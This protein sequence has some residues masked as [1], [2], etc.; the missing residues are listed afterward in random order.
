MAKAQWVSTVA[1]IVDTPGSTNGTALSARFFIPHGI[2]A[3]TFGRIFIADRNN[4]IIR[5][6][7]TNT[8]MV[9]T[10]AGM[11]GEPG[12]ANGIG[13]AARF[14]EPWGICATPDGEVY[15]AD[16][17]NNMVRKVTLDGTVTTI[18]GTGNYGS[19][20]GVGIASTFG[21]PTG[22]ERDADGNL[23]V[24]DHLTHIIRKINK[25]G[26]VS[27]LAGSPYVPGDADGTGANA[28]FWRPYGLTLDH[29]GNLLVADEWNHKIRKV[30]PQGEVTTLAGN[31]IDGLTDGAAGNASFSYPWD[32]TVDADGNV[33]VGD[34][35]NYVVRK[36]STDGVVTTFSGTPQSPGIQDGSG[37]IAKFKGITS[38]A[39]SKQSGNLV[40]CDAFNHLIRE[41]SVEGIPPVTLSL[42]NLEG[43]SKIC[44]GDDFNL[45]AAPSTFDNY[46]FYLDGT[47]VQDN[48]SSDFTSSQ[49]TPGMHT[50]VA[51]TKVDGQTLTSNPVV[52]TVVETPQP[53]ISAVGP[54]SFYEGDSVILFASGIG[55]FLW[56]NAETDQTITVSESGSYFVELSLNGCTG[57]SPPIEVTVTDLPDA[58]SV[59]VQGNNRLCPG[60]SVVLA[61]SA[62]SGNQWFR[63]GWPISG[64]NGQTIE[65]TEAGLY[66]VQSTDPNTGIT[67]LSNEVEIKQPQAF[68]F[69]FG[70]TPS[71]A[72]PG[73]PIAFE[74]LGTDQPI[75]FEWQFG[76]PN[77]GLQNT[78]QEPKPTHVFALEGSYTIQLVATDLNGC[79]HTL[80]KTDFVEIEKFNGIYLPNAFTP[81]GDGENDQFR[82]RGLVN[83]P[84][85]MIIFNQWGEL[86]FQSENP[87][88][89]WDGNRNGLPVQPGTFIYLVKLEVEGKEQEI[90]GKVTLLR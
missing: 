83:G 67:A 3:D 70:A 5:L 86:L 43:A 33:Y 53:T 89:G 13:S 65:V 88:T 19:S 11:A 56:S 8:G 52:I 36:I 75:A 9:T 66:M 32:V 40:A 73:Q 50:I 41:I 90:S 37:N 76:D 46:R 4:H 42:L 72:A 23:Y 34:G 82:V 64:Q 59:L 61:S 78:S 18:A 14:N 47:M 87:S 60:S 45:V 29:E 7:D 10:L 38:L 84:F 79:K 21:N 48:A 58:L 77:A 16:T 31:G 54:T 24:A 1:G 44:E 68:V 22:I 74:T 15:V 26:N 30:T 63:D 62:A 27:T 20:N 85:S 55:E 49:L 80:L 12:S 39:W 71:N 51:E 28:E 81:N 35:Y 2:A 69:D 57:I 25:L 6:L 17:K